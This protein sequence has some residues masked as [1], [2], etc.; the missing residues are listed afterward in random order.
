MSAPEPDLSK[1]QRR[2]RGPVLGILIL[3]ALTI[4]GFV[5]WMGYETADIPK[6]GDDQQPVD[7]QSQPADAP[8]EPSMPP[9]T[10]A[11]PGTQPTN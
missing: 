5:W 9:Q 10:P 11:S 3:V 8:A 4:L 1:Q 7:E 2:H 6:P